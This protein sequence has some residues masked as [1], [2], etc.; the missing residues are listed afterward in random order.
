[1][2][3][4]GWRVEGVEFSPSAAKTAINA[5]YSVHVGPLEH[6]PKPAEP[7]DLIVGWMVVEHLHDPVAALR[8]MRGWV[9]P[10]GWLVMSVPNAGSFEFRAF[11]A[12][13]YALQL[14]T[15]LYHFTPA[16]IE[17]MLT[18]SGW[19]VDRVHHQ[20]VINN[21]IASIGYSLKQR[22]WARVGDAFVRLAERGGK[23]SSLMLYPLSLL[24]AH[25]GQ[26]GRM[27]IWA[28]PARD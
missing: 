23:L 18:K 17:K 19:V 10:D 2:S 6:A 8:K 16:T 25:F 4:K 27:T 1:M 28:R 11:G 12:N 21:L 15:H 26:T 7:L 24:L 13:W 20:R 22:H 3:D 14:P 5:G 9:K